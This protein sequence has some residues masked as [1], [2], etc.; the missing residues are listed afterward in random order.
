MIEKLF[1]ENSELLH[2]VE[3]KKYMNYETN[4]LEINLSDFKATLCIKDTKKFSVDTYL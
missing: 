1:K 3:I 2:K 4:Q